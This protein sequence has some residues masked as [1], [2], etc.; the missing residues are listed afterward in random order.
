MPR[1]FQNVFNAEFVYIGDYD[2]R[3]DSSAAYVVKAGEVVIHT[4][5][6]ERITE[7]LAND[8]S[9]IVF[10]S[11]FLPASAGIYGESG[12]SVDSWKFFYPSEIEVAKKRVGVILLGSKRAQSISRSQTSILRIIRQRLASEYDRE[13]K[14]IE[15]RQ[16]E[17]QLRQSQKMES[18]GTLAGGVAH[19]FNNMLGVML[20][21]ASLLRLELKQNEKLSSYASTV[22]KS[23]RRAAELT[24]QLLGFARAGKTLVKNVDLNSICV[25][26]AEMTK[27]MIEKNVEVSLNLDSDLPPVEGDES[28][29]SQV[30]MNL[31]VNARD[32]MRNGGKLKI[33]TRF[34]LAKNVAQLNLSL[35]RKDYVVVEVS[36]TG[37]GIPKEN[38]SR[39]FE[40]FFTTKPKGEGTGLGLSVVYGI[41]KN[42]GGDV[43]VYSDVGNG[44]T[45]EVYLPSSLEKA[46][47]DYQRETGEFRKIVEG[48]VCLVV[49]DELQVRE[50]LTEFLRILGFDVVAVENG[51]RALRAI[52]Q[53]QRI[54]VVILDMIMPGMDGNQ[55]FFEIHKLKPDLPILVATG[56][57]AEGKVQEILSQGGMGI[58]HKPFTLEELEGHLAGKFRDFGQESISR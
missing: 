13:M 22:E 55:T 36:D 20:G 8:S 48:K 21:Y 42:H 5:K 26:T 33:S 19:D 23:A 54:D 15:T 53:N 10:L 45:F 51:E 32:A 16:L 12:R 52:E 34:Q 39:I 17:E 24:K 50:L 46:P 9:G 14:M 28:Q 41:V 38:L 3:E 47:E 44:T 4:A 2:E 29:L 40:P 7:L 35:D 37:H 1:S 57:S 11:R 31:V 43:A 49:D 27:K 18:L 30:I 25:E 6:V 58:L 56:Y